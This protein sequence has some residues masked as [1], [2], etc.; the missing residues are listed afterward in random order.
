MARCRMRTLVDCTEHD[1]H[2]TRHFIIDCMANEYARRPTHGQRNARQFTV[3][4]T[5]W[6]HRTRRVHDGTIVSTTNRLR[7]RVAVCTCGAR[8]RCDCSPKCTYMYHIENRT[9]SDLV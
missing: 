8:V 3:C 1:R 6:I 2:S 9:F 5:C 4:G 7:E